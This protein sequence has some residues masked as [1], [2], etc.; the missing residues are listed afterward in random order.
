MFGLLAVSMSLGGLRSVSATGGTG[1]PQTESGRAL[2]AM[3]PTGAAASSEELD[4]VITST[5]LPATD[6]AFR[7]IA[8]SRPSCPPSRRSGWSCICS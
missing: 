8:S 5:S 7:A 1:A 6:P 2:A 4:A 3:N